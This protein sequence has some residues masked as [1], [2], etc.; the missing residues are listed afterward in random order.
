MTGFDEP[1]TRR[2]EGWDDSGEDPE[3]VRR[4]AI[5][6]YRWVT[7]DKAEHAEEWRRREPEEFDRRASR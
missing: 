2:Y 7:V 1:V 6:P 3:T 5:P 4:F